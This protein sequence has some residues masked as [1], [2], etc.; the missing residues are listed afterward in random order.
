MLHL[1]YSAC[2]LRPVYR[3]P[4]IWCERTNFHTNDFDTWMSDCAV[5]RCLADFFLW[6]TLC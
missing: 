3:D 5:W 1:L 4:M 6:F 2:L